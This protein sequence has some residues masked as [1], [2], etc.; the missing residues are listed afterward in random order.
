MHDFHYRGEELYCEEVPV[1]QVARRVGT[2]FYL[3]SARTLAR[4]VRAF[5]EAFAARPHLLCFAV[6]ANGNLAVLH[7]LGRLGT[8]ADIVS[9]GELHRALM[10]GIPPERIVYSGVGKTAREIRRALEAGILLFNVESL[11]E[12]DAI[13]AE[14]RRAGRTARVAFRVNPDVDPKT[15]PYISTGLERNKFGIP[16]AQAREA[17]ARAARLP[18]IEVAGVDCHIGSQLTELAPFVDALRRVKALVEELAADGHEIRYLDLGG[19]LGIPYRDEA[20]PAPADYARA[21]LAEL[22]GWPQTLVLEPG[23]AIAGNAGILVTRLLYTKETPRKR[24]LVVDAAMNDLARPSLYQAHHEI[25][26]VRRAGPPVGPADV[27]GPI[28]ESGDFLARDRDLPRFPR[29]AL[30]AVMSAGAYGFTMS[31]NY[32]ARPRVPEVLVRGERFAVV[33]RRETLAQLVRGESI[34]GFL[35]E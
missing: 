11:P 7:L 27:V 16:M 19:G 12:L 22:E 2:P 33:R 23:R 35:A 25:L 31:S 5:Q 30:L 8:G 28:C 29:R 10:A 21:I 13:A 3:Y 18:G 26:P 4:H 20:P 1:A 6:K 24:F 15:H 9:G 32:N 34:P 14:A 17:Y